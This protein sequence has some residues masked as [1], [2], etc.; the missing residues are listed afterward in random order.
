MIGAI[1]RTTVGT[2]LLY[3]FHPP[4]LSPAI[5][6]ALSP[7]ELA[8]L[9]GKSPVP[10]SERALQHPVGQNSPPVSVLQPLSVLAHSWHR[11]QAHLAC[12]MP[13]GGNPGQLAEAHASVPPVPGAH[14]LPV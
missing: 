10:H 2:G 1:S 4:S 8:C 3:L 5:S 11:T 14:H 12:R 9:G 6:D 13:V 7:R